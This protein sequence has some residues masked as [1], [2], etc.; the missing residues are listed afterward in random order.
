M[1]ACEGC[2]FVCDKKGDWTRHLT[3]KKHRRP[4]LKCACGAEFRQRGAQIA[5]Q[6]DCTFEKNGLILQVL[7]ENKELRT[8]LLEQQR[9]L[10]ELIPKIGNVTT[11]N[12]FNLNVFLNEKCKDAVNWSDFISTLKVQLQGEDSLTNGI[13]KIICDGLHDLGVHKRPIH[14]LDSKRKKLCIKN[15]DAWE[16]DSDK[17]QSTLHQTARSIQTRYIKELKEWQSM[18]PLW[19]ESESETEIFTT[20]VQRVTGEIDDSHYTS[21]I[22]R[23]ASIPKDE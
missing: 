16:H 3:T 11:N 23:N 9:Q 14:C 1:F 7:E 18:H 13:A 4:V 21:C 2:R 8:I 12:K 20:L 19:V 17:V 10:S 5:H 22:L 6:L 15:E